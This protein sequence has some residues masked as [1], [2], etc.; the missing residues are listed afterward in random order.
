MRRIWGERGAGD[1]KGR[2]HLRRAGIVLG[3]GALLCAGV[4]ASGALGM[5]LV[6][7]GST[8]ST[9]TA[10]DTS[11][12]STFTPT[13]HSDQEDYNPGATVTLSGAGWGP[14][15]SVHIVV[16][17]DKS[18]PWSYATDATAD[19]SGGFSVQF[20]LPTSFAAAYAVQATGSSGRV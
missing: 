3:F 10:A 16:N 7:S 12:A 11:P 1:M 15:E 13:I 14:S 17:D 5:S 19:L 20:Q 8:D 6:D 2:K 9:S 18:Q 4:M